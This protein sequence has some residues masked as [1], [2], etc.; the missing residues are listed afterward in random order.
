MLIHIARDVDTHENICKNLKDF[1]TK[2]QQELLAL[3]RELW[4]SKV[5]KTYTK[6]DIPLDYPD[7]DGV[8][9]YEISWEDMEVMLRELLQAP[10]TNETEPNSFTNGLP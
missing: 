9:E 3:C 4:E 7:R 1:V 2:G 8:E 10:I 5:K 6:K